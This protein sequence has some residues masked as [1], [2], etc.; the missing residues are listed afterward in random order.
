MMCF[1][2]AALAVA[3]GKEG[4]V[5]Y[6][7]GYRS[8]THVK[9]MAI[10]SAEHPLFESFGGIH[11]VY[12]N[13]VGER[14]AREG[15]PYP[16]GSVLVFDLLAAEQGSGAYTEGTRRFVGVM[17]RDRKAYASTG[18]WGFEAFK[19]DSRERI[20]TDGKG[21]CFACHQGQE[22]SDY[23]FSTWRR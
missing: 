3:R 2:F 22:S 12:V 10:T 20:V 1:G 16:D 6:P 11:H 7:E 23:V 21:Q 18:G 14:A 5:P 13:A 19:G 15:Q 4:P 17:R 9:S 8:W